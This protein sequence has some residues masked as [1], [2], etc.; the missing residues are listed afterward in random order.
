MKKESD[1][2][3]F[4]F[5]VKMLENVFDD[6][7]ETCDKIMDYGI[8]SHSLTL[9]E[10]DEFQRFKAS[11]KYLKTKFTKN[12]HDNFLYAKRLFEQFPEG[13]PITSLSTDLVSNFRNESELKSEFEIATFAALAAIKSII[14]NKPYIKTTNKFLIA[15]M[16]GY[17]SMKDVPEV[18]PEKLQKYSSR[19][20]LNRIKTAIEINNWGINIFSRRNIRGLYVS[21][22]SKFT[23]DQLAKV[24]AENNQRYREKQLKRKKEEAYKKALLLIENTTT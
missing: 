15:R 18:L 19:R 5:P 6:I 7:C 8:Y 11:A 14:G 24:A 12:P 22:N 1:K 13:S 3:Y 21:L 16:G 2:R 23:L 4:T 17:A 10:G 9:D 20:R